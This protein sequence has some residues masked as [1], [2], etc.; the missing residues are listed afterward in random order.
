MKR[1]ILITLAIC[2]TFSFVSCGNDDDEQL[3]ERSIDGV[4]AYLGY[5][6]GVDIDL[7]E[8]MDGTG[9]KAGKYFKDGKVY[10]YEFDPDSSTYKYWQ[11]ETDTCVGGFVLL[12]DPDIDEEPNDYEILEQTERIQNI[13]FKPE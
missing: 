13:K 2:L 12:F 10:I 3:V 8:D 5:T 6:D 4:A 11:S 7:S 1:I 9:A